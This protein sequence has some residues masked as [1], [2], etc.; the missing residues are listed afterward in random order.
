M[1]ST[2]FVTERKKN[3]RNIAIDAKSHLTD[4]KSVYDE[5]SQHT[6]NK[7]ERPQPDKGRLQKKTT[8]TQNKTNSLTQNGEFN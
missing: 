4:F 7:R 8:H 2:V 6:G 1:S 3:H 5:R